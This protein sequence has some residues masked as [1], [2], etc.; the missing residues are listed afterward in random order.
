M[1]IQD[2]CKTGAR[3]PWL[4]VDFFLTLTHLPLFPKKK[5]GSKSVSKFV[6]REKKLAKGGEVRAAFIGCPRGRTAETAV[7]LEEEEEEHPSFTYTQDDTKNLAGG[8]R[9]NYFFLGHIGM[10]F[11]FP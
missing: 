8:A 1:A 2:L 9:G 4:D 11:G 5:R 6:T 10:A 7:V 3:H